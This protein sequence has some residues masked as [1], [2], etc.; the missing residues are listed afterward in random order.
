MSFLFVFFITLVFMIALVIALSFGR[1][2]S[3]RPSRKKVLGVLDSIING[4]QKSDEWFLFLGIPIVHDSY[5][6]SIRLRCV[7]IDELNRE[8]PHFHCKEESK[9]CYYEK[10]LM[11]QLSDIREELCQVIEKMPITRDF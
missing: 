3:Y 10:D 8:N 2:P 1:V 4:N 5:L 9:N 6:E 11:S 7:E